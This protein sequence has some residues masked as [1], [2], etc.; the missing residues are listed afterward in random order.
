MNMH[1]MD[2]RAVSG[3]IHDLQGDEGEIRRFITIFTFFKE[4]EKEFP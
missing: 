1:D 2:V 3:E 4:R